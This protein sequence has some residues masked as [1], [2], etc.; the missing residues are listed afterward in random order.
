[1][2]LSDMEIT[3][4]ENGMAQMP[5]HSAIMPSKSSGVMQESSVQPF[6]NAEDE[7]EATVAN[8]MNTSEMESAS[9]N[10]I[11]MTQP[12]QRATMASKSNGKMQEG[13]DVDGMSPHHQVHDDS[14][15]SKPT[16]S[17]R[18]LA[19]A[20]STSV[21]HRNVNDGTSITP[22]K[23]VAK[24]AF[25]M[26]DDGMSMGDLSKVHS[27]YTVAQSAGEQ[28]VFVCLF[29]CL[30]IF[31]CLMCLLSIPAEHCGIL[32]GGFMDKGDIGEGDM[33]SQMNTISTGLDMMSTVTS[34]LLESQHLSTHPQVVFE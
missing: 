30:F 34:F 29:V 16:D 32:I 1:M 9:G 4:V 10:N 31:S 21:P 28:C 22:A 18:A 3:G 8:Q 7:F 25:S 17:I 2:Q 23:P 14:L 15:R 24:H 33:S 11:E 20:G 6:T 13:E 12:E 27:G 26:N 19:Q 5:Q